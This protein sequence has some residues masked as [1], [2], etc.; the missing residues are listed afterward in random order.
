MTWPRLC[1]VAEAGWSNQSQKNYESFV[2]R[3]ENELKLFDKMRIS[4]FDHKDPLRSTEP[5]GCERNTKKESMDFR[6]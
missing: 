2:V 5:I 3:L 6:D 4:Y 1:A